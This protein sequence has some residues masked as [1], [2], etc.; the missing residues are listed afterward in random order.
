[1]ENHESSIYLKLFSNKVHNRC[2]L[3][4]QNIPDFNCRI[5][6][7]SISRFA[8]ALWPET[9]FKQEHKQIITNECGKRGTQLEIIESF[10]W[11]KKKKFRRNIEQYMIE[12][13]LSNPKDFEKDKTQDNALNVI[14]VIPQNGKRLKVV[15][16]KIGSQTIKLITAYYLD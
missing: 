16:R 3:G 6:P 5:S 10:H 8:P 9:A 4:Q 15:F 14:M 1:M 7:M 2:L 13:A 11:K 12:Y